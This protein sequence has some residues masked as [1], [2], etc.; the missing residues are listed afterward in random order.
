MLRNKHDLTK[1]E[2]V[3]WIAK[4]I[5]AEFP[6]EISG[7]KFCLLD[8]GCI[9]YQ[10]V[11]SDGRVD[12]WTA[13]YRDVGYGVCEVCTLKTVNWRQMISKIIV[14]YNIKLEVVIQD[15]A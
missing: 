5:F 13:A 15:I 8:C 12:S 4:T 1:E 2:R 3:E 9:Y 6:N 14:V 10:R 11:C 7:L